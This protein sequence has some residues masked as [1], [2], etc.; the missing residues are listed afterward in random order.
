MY[1]ELK[2]KT[3][4]VLEERETEI[5]F[6]REEIAYLIQ[7]NQQKEA[8][9]VNLARQFTALKQIQSAGEAKTQVSEI[10]QPKKEEEEEEEKVADPLT[11]TQVVTVYF[12]EYS[13]ASQSIPDS[14]SSEIIHFETFQRPCSSENDNKKDDDKEGNY[15]SEGVDCFAKGVASEERRQVSSSS[16]NKWFHDIK[17]VV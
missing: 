11:G 10:Q 13:N 17:Y 7:S 4:E 2:E 14:S 9:I 12:T 8:V 3:R 6:L 1:N 5:N 15:L 16:P